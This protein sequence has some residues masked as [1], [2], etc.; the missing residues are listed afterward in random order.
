MSENVRTPVV[1]TSENVRKPYRGSDVSDGGLAFLTLPFRKPVASLVH[2]GAVLMRFPFQHNAQRSQIRGA[3]R[4]IE[5]QREFVAWWDEKVSPNRG[6][7]RGNQHTGGKSAERRTWR[8]SEIEKRTGISNQQVSRRRNLTSSQR[9]AYAVEIL[10][11]LE[12]EAAARRRATQ[13]NK[14]DQ[15]LIPEQDKGQAR[16]KAAALVGT[17][18]HYVSD[19][20]LTG[21]V[22]T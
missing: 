7:D 13:N 22:H 2:R 21:R 14:A 19:A 15:E 6:G 8:V 3:Q 5:E 18:S 4:R 9:A 10:P 16:D 20:K 1:Q 11:E 17:N 12:A